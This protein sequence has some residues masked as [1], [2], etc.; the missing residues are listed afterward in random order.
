MLDLRYEARN[1]D[2]EL[3]CP[4][5]VDKWF[6]AKTKGMTDLSRPS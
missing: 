4:D 1:I 6:D 2:Q 3:T 5:K